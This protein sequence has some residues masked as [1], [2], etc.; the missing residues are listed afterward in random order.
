MSTDNK[1]H[2][3]RQSK[4]FAELSQPPNP[5]DL[6]NNEELVKLYLNK[7][8]VAPIPKKLET[9]YEGA[10]RGVSVAGELTIGKNLS[11]RYIEDY[12]FWK[13]KDQ[14]K[15]RTRKLMIQKQFKGRKKVKPR[16]CWSAEDDERLKQLLDEAPTTSSHAHTDTSQCSTS[17]F[18]ASSTTKTCVDSSVD[19]RSIKSENPETNQL[20]YTEESVDILP[21]MQKEALQSLGKDT[22]D[23]EVN[24][25]QDAEAASSAHEGSGI[26][27]AELDGIVDEDL[28]KEFIEAMNSED[29]IFCAPTFSRPKSRK[30][31][32]PRERR[33]SVRRSARLLKDNTQ[34][35]GSVFSVLDDITPSKRNSL[36]IQPENSCTVPPTVSERRRANGRRY[37]AKIADSPPEDKEN[38][39]ALTSPPCLLPLH[40][41][42]RRKRRQRRPVSSFSTTGG[43]E[44]A[45][46][47]ALIDQ[48]VQPSSPAED[49]ELVQLRETDQSTNS[50]LAQISRVS[51]LDISETVLADGK[52]QDE[53]LSS[54]CLAPK[55]KQDY[56]SRS[57]LLPEENQEPVL[58]ENLST[59]QMK[60]TSRSGSR[61]GS[62]CQD[63]S[64]SERLEEEE[65]DSVLR[66]PSEPHSFEKTKYRHLLDNLQGS[67]DE[68]IISGM[69]GNRR[70]APRNI[71]EKR[72]HN[73][74]SVSN[75]Y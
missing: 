48:R 31:K 17:L 63:T 26:D 9:L 34:L 30:S 60:R 22:Q 21:N 28:K 29:L 47:L 5:E 73:I 57:F 27:P 20:V 51:S 19:Q 8:Y 33:L 16:Q 24:L 10:R 65:I 66:T 52:I 18:V 3:R 12:Q 53:S 32:P 2:R 44:L 67:D 41:N 39:Y 71:E 61:G 62:G 59:R 37:H 36:Q 6:E 43:G 45:N 58:S 64:L 55:D 50:H 72:L 75:M 54:R 40:T 49:E 14:T 7:N 68:D 13:K 25:V 56:S 23:E 15:N 4:I 11:K 38:T 46:Q 70:F 35:S 1:N 42:P 69:I 74:A